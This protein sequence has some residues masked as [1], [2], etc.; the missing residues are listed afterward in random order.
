MI[1]LTRP[2]WLRSGLRIAQSLNVPPADQILASGAKRRQVLV[3]D[4]STDRHVAHAQLGSG[5]L[6]GQQLVLFHAADGT[7]SSEQHNTLRG[8]T[9]FN[10]TC[11]I[12][13]QFDV[14][15]PR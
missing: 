12:R 3:C 11:I 5:F 4:P 14:G 8:F 15:S 2:A 1:A 7:A 10:E 9:G 6:N 13:S